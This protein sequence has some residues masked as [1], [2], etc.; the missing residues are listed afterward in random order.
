[1]IGREGL[2]RSS[3]LSWPIMSR[4]STSQ[5]KKKNQSGQ[6]MFNLPIKQRD[7]VDGP[8]IEPPANF[9]NIYGKILLR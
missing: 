2:A 9:G 6:D 5:H 1:M 8:R 3:D 4:L 7:A